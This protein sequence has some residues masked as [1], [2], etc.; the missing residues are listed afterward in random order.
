[1][2][3]ALLIAKPST[4]ISICYAHDRRV[5]YIG[6]L[7]V[8]PPCVSAFLASQCVIVVDDVFAC[9]CLRYEFF[10][11]FEHLLTTHLTGEKGFLALQSCTFF[12]LMRASICTYNTCM[13]V[14]QQEIFQ[15]CVDK[16]S[17][18]LHLN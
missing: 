1:M 13:N 9:A 5:K 7:E 2:T 8:T 6:S 14:G 12:L 15:R 11:V 17:F 16:I 4:C 10:I 18:K 3:V